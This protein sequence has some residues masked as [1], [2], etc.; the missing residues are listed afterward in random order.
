MAAGKRGRKRVRIGPAYDKPEVRAWLETV[1]ALPGRPGAEILHRARNTVTAVRVPLAD[2]RTLDLAVKEFSPRGLHR[3]RTLFGR[4]K[5]E[6][7]ARGAARLLAAG[8]RTPA[9]VAVVER[10]R[11][12]TVE[13]AWFAA[14]RVRD[15]VEIRAFFRDLE[16]DDL[17]RLLAVLARELRAA[18]E[19]GL[20]HRDLSDGNILVECGADGAFRLHF[21]DTNRVRCRRRLGG[22][23][24]AKNLIRLGIPQGRRREFLALYAGGV[25]P[26]PAFI[27]RYERSKAAF[28]RWLRFKKKAR[29]RQWARRLK[30]Q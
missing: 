20:L 15:A 11:R 1:E 21:L 27:R 17:G 4:S 5:A 22:R 13:K 19:A 2:G 10:R 3:L 16:G 18:H 12:G 30:L 14:E 9:P 6:R 7:A 8:L 26:E 23:A 28:E 25:G 29:L 24:R